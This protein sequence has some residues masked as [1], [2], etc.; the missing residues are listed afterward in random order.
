MATS[1]ERDPP[2]RVMAKASKSN[3]SSSSL[4]WR[5]RKQLA[6]K[7]GRKQVQEQVRVSYP[8]PERFDPRKWILSWLGWATTE[9]AIAACM[10]SYTALLHEHP[11]RLRYQ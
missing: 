7:K 2:P 6:K 9:G 8:Q 10:D 3:S 4:L 11:G 5:R 1:D